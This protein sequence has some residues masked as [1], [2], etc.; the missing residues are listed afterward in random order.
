MKLKCTRHDRRVMVLPSTKVIHRNDGS[1]CSTNV[2]M[3]DYE[4]TPLMAT[5]VYGLS[6]YHHLEQ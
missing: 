2:K 4:Y 6:I 1:E 3:G 5:T